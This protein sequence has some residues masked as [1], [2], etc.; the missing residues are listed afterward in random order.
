MTD[1][2]TTNMASCVNC[3]NQISEDFCPK[4]GQSAKLK[5]IDKHY[6]SHELL[7]LF[8]FEKGF[9]YTAKELLLRPG[10]SIKEF[11]DK[12]R[13][14]HM[15]PVPFLILTSVLFALVANFTHSDKIFDD[16]VS[17]F[18]TSKVADIFNWMKA[19]HGYG[20]II[21]GIFIALS[22]KLFFR[23]YKYNL[24][25]IVILMCFVI[26]Q[27]TLLLAIT[28]LFFGVLKAQLYQTI[29]TIISFG[30]SAWAIGQFF[31]GR[32]ILGFIKAL[33][34]YVFGMF[35]FTIVVVIVGKTADLI[36][37]ILN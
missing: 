30:Y 6:V 10:D 36:I 27:G 28:T 19:H 31:Y 33:S 13:N 20:N 14:K 3:N 21:E 34:V 18:G 4:C 32:K 12:N 37:K 16:Q 1:N 8:H 2:I 24:F 22:V 25:E 26:G 17:T 15:K 35:V 7:H 11:I 9:F 5:R 29:I 23:K